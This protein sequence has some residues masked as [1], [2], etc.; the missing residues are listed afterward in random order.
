MS[1][2]TLAATRSITLACHLIVSV[3]LCLIV[4][5]CRVAELA[6]ATRMP[7]TT[8]TVLGACGKAVLCAG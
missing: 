4:L 6:E 7:V 2:T 1:A 8:Q 3:M 5:L